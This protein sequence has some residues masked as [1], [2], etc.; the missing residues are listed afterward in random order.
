MSAV[1]I[2]CSDL[3]LGLQDGKHIE[4]PRIAYVFQGGLGKAGEQSNPDVQVKRRVLL[5]LWKDMLDV[6]ARDHCG[7]RDIDYII[8]DCDE[9]PATVVNLVRRFV[10]EKIRLIHCGCNLDFDAMEIPENDRILQAGYIPTTCGN[11]EI[12][13]RVYRE[14]MQTGGIPYDMTLA[15]ALFRRNV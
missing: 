1:F 14:Y 6:L 15:E 3:G 12:S 4:G 11:V 2:T 10:P 9:L 13:G 5:Q 8:I 7:V